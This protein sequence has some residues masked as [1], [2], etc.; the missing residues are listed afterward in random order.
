MPELNLRLFHYM[1]A[2]FT[3]NH[4]LLPLAS[5]IA[6]DGF[7][8]SVIL[9]GWAVWRHRSQRGYVFATLIACA[10]AATA[11][12]A[13]AAS[14]NW[15]RP[16]MLGLSP[17]YVAHGDRGSLPSAHVTVMFTI[18]LAFLLRQSLWRLGLLMIAS[19]AL[20]GWAR[21]YVGIHFPIDIVAGSLLAAGIVGVLCAVIGLSRRYLFPLF[22]SKA[23][24]EVTSEPMENRVLA[25]SKQ[26]R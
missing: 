14:L 3:P 20:T 10:V 4:L 18:A 8:I 11:A 5:V 17:V 7:W 23:K 22:N 24:T 21:V 2:G 9:M 19:A 25:P 16:F 1:A 12:H 13:I 26:R 15:P 6:I